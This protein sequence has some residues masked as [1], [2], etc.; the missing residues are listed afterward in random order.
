M[1]LETAMRLYQHP[2]SSNS[3]RAMLAAT[4]L[5]VAL[6][7]VE[8]NLGSPEDRR[9]LV[10]VNPN[11]KVP[12]LE[13]DGMLLWESCAIMQYLADLTPGQTVYPQDLRARADVNRW[14]F[15]AAQHF[16][17]A[18]GIFTWENVWK[19]FVEGTDPD[20]AE[21]ARGTEELTAA[22]KVLDGYLAARQWLVGDSVTLA[23]F[24]V[25]ASL[26]YIDK[27]RVPVEPYPNI[28]AWF[29]RVQALPAWQHTNPVW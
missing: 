29:E 7:L 5:G 11:S 8:I 13:H 20:P 9:R 25:S 3:R 4:H 12:V 26:M 14:M 16:A 23:D 17:P 6:E 24:A 2:L 21:L 22:A 19:K 27:A 1:T 10:E 15:W 28:L 18:I